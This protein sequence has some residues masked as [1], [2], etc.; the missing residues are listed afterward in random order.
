MKKLIL[1]MCLVSSVSQADIN[2]LGPIP[3]NEDISTL[4]E[5]RREI[6]TLR[7]ITSLGLNQAQTG[8]DLWSGSYWPHYQGLLGARYQDVNYLSLMM[9]EVQYKEY[10]DLVDKNPLYSVRDS[11]KLSPAEKYD[12][13]VGDP[14]MSLTKYSW[15]IGKK[16]LVGSKVP[17]WRGLCDGWAS[18][19]Q[20]MPRPV[21][22]V[23]VMT[24]NGSPLTFTHDDIKALGSLLYARNQGP[25]IFLGKRCRSPL[26]FVSDACQETNPGAF[27]KALAN[28]VGQMKK[29]FIADISPGSEVWNYPVKSYQFTYYNVF[30]D[31]ESPNYLEVMESFDKKK[32]FKGV[33][34][35]HKDT[36]YIVG[37][38]AKVNYTDMRPADLAGADNLRLDKTLEKVYEYDLELDFN[39][40]ILGGYS[41]SKNLPDFVWAPND[42]TY[43]L[44]DAEEKKVPV[45]RAEIIKQSQEAAKDGQPLAIIVKS[46]FEA[47]R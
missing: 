37:V 12:L 21:N 36:K 30:T 32:G 33:S 41:Y 4:L 23:T 26:L 3:K 45:T 6:Q 10:K 20:M 35:R 15:E 7:E 34:S 14:L 13:L 11:S 1:G 25:T 29:T 46:L 38:V 5:G 47:S 28:R 27:H 31:Q 43:P 2:G 40:K 17:T 44:S 22:P 9:R 19:S 8:I 42:V 18:A 24:P 16:A 39:G